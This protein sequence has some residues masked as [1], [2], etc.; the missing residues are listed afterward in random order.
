MTVAELVPCSLD[1]ARCLVALSLFDNA[2]QGAF[3]RVPSAV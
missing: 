1:T 3:P 2:G